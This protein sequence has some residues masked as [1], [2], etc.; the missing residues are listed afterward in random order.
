MIF[1]TLPKPIIY[2]RTGSDFI[3]PG[4]LAQAHS[5]RFNVIQHLLLEGFTITLR[6]ID[7]CGSLLF[8]VST[9]FRTGQWLGSIK[10]TSFLLSALC[11]L[12]CHL[13]ASGEPDAFALTGVG[14]RAGGMGN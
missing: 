11:F 2:S 3:T 1:S 10:K 6:C 7:H 12:P 9:I 4:C 8:G 13:G 14:A 5:S